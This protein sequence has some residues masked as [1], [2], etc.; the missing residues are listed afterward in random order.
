MIRIISIEYVLNYSKFLQGRGGILINPEGII[1][2]HYPLGW[3]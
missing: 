3:E 1:V 2:D